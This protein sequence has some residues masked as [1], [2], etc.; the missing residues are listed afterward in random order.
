MNSDEEISF[1]F[2][3]KEF[4]EKLSHQ[5]A[6][7]EARRRAS[8]SASEPAPEL[9]AGSIPIMET[10]YSSIIGRILQSVSGEPFC[11]QIFFYLSVLSVLGTAFNL[12]PYTHFNL[13]LILEEQEYWRIFSWPLAGRGVFSNC[14][15]ALFAYCHI[16]QV[17]TK[18][19]SCFT[20]LT[21]LSNFAFASFIPLTLYPL[22]TPET[23]I[24]DMEQ[25]TN[26]GLWN[27][28]FFF[29][30]VT[31]IPNIHESDWF[32]C[33]RV[34]IS[35]QFNVIGLCICWQFLTLGDIGVILG[36]VFG[37]FIIYG[38]PNWRN[39]Q[40]LDQ[41]FCCFRKTESF[42]TLDASIFNLRQI[43]AEK[44]D[45]PRHVPPSLAFSSEERPFLS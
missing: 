12:A 4:E 32:L 1:C 43:H 18:L 40:K 10:S 13:R 9:A 34:T 31:I 16:K 17:E 26:T 5:A 25:V 30:T 3:L 15:S 37:F 24:L 6:Q 27:I 8:R 44:K 35:R 33:F 39:I 19:G 38:F 28:T 45:H 29:F 36:T 11:C 23:G 41:C 20:A 22:C 21:F 14:I 7:M 42:I 2:D